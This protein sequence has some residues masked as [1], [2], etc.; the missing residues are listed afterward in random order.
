MSV[1]ER[2]GVV[3][4]WAGSL[5]YPSQEAF[6]DDMVEEKYNLEDPDSI[7][8]ARFMTD[9]QT[10]W[11]DHD[12][13]EA[14]YSETMMTLGTLLDDASYSESFAAEVLGAHADREANTIILLYD[15]E[16]PAELGEK[17]RDKPLKFLGVY[18]YEVVHDE[19]FLKILSGESE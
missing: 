5:D 3:S 16:Y 15:Y 4:I 13:R 7:A 14:R 8:Y 1:E 10:G 11:Y 17:L 6:R 2:K 19:W 9:Y 18:D 12:F